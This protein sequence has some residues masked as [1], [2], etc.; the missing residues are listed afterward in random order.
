MGS[1]LGRSWCK[2]REGLRIRDLKNTE[3]Y[4][5]EEQPVYKSVKNKTS[6]Q[7]DASKIKERKRLKGVWN[8]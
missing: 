6:K 4:W 8:E 3:N 1:L 2:K 5:V 7:K